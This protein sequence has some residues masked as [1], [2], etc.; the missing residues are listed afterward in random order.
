MLII[1]GFSHYDS[2]TSDYF[3]NNDTNKNCRDSSDS[4]PNEIVQ[5]QK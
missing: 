5:M 1:Q 4:E 3:N 2:I